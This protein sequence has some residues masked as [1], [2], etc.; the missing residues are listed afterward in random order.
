M[1]AAAVRALVDVIVAFDVTS[2]DRE[3]LCVAI[4]DSERMMRWLQ[5]R[6]ALLAR[7][8]AVVDAVA[9]HTLAEVARIDPRVASKLLKRGETTEMAPTL[10]AAVLD[11]DVSGEHVDALSRTLRSV[12]PPLRPRLV[13]AAESL[14]SVAA[15]TTAE[16]FARRLQREARRLQTDDGMARFERQRRDTRLRTWTDRDTGMWCLSGRFDPRTGATL[17]RALHDELSRRYAEAVPAWSPSDP[18]EK[19]DYLRARALQSLIEGKG[20]AVGRPE[21]IVVVDTRDSDPATGGPIVDWGIPIEVPTTVLDDVVSRAAVHTVKVRNGVVI[22]APGCL[23]LGRTT[24][25]AN[26]AQRRALRALY[27]TCGVLGCSTPFDCCRIHHIIEWES[28]GTT[29]LVNL[30]PV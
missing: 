15:A 22:E 24:R 20:G 12:E 30:L 27:P 7:Q 4:A 11:G 26:R 28:G 21:V 1:D 17:S 8:I 5:G 13:E 9:E 29:D 23:N 19:Q 2:T 25:L 18:M 14:V 3:A 16:E 10:A 6:Q